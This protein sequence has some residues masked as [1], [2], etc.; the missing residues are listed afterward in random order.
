MNVLLTYYKLED[1]LKDDNGLKKVAYTI[2]KGRLKSAYE[3]YPKKAEFIKGQLAAIYFF[4]NS[5]FLGYFS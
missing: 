5:A 2:Y 1:N 3:K 4:I